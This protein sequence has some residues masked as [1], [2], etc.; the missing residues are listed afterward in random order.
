MQITD[1]TAYLIAAAC[2]QLKYLNLERAYKVC[3]QTD[4]LRIL[5]NSA[6]TMVWLAMASL[7]IPVFFTSSAAAAVSSRSTLTTSRR[8]RAPP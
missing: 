8:C 6:D 1:K 5:R 4:G 7:P 2:P 3:K